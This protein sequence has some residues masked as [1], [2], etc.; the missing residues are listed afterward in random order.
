[1]KNQ[2]LHIHDVLKN[3]SKKRNWPYMS[4]ILMKNINVPLFEEVTGQTDNEWII[5]ATKNRICIETE[6]VVIRYVDGKNLSLDHIYRLND[7][8][9]S[10]AFFKDNPSVIK[11]LHGSMG[12]YLYVMEDMKM[13]R[14]YFLKS[15]LDIKTVLYFITSFNTKLSKFIIKKFGVFG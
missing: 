13:A 15:T 9:Y 11:K 6:P 5:E 3:R 2:T 8:N 1:M 12:R 14:K 4:S 7:F 10:L